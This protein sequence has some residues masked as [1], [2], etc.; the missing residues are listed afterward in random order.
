MHNITGNS[1]HILVDLQLAIHSSVINPDEV[2]DGLNELLNSVMSSDFIADY[3]FNDPSNAEV[4]YS[5]CV[6]E[7]G[8]LF[9]VQAANANC[10]RDNQLDKTKLI[11][12]VGFDCLSSSSFDWFESEKLARD[13]FEKDKS[14]TLNS[15]PAQSHLF[16]LRVDSG[17][18]K[19]EITNE[20][21]CFYSEHS[22]ER[23]FNTSKYVTSYPYLPEAWLSIS[24]Y[25]EE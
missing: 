16:L 18:S 11:W 12:V 7:E 21:D 19:D 6:P 3:K 9:A 4:V 25:S 5:S 15:Q 2:N 10:Y 13:F 23:E 14:F 20:V 8:E 22:R 24:K 17:Q 1:K